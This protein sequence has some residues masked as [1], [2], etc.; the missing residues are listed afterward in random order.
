MEIKTYDFVVI[1][2]GLSG[3]AAAVSSARNGMKVALIGNRPVPGGNAS[4]EIGIDVNGACY[5]SLYSPSV[6]ARETGLIEELKQEIFHRAGYEPSLNKSAQY[7]ATML[8]FLYDEENLDLYLNTQATDVSVK[9]N[10][11]EYVDCIQ[12]TSERK[13]RFFASTFADC[14]G[15][16]FVGA[17]AGAKFMSG[18]EGRAEYGENLAPEQPSQITN[19]CSLLFS[20]VRT[21]KEEKFIPPHFAYDITKLDFFKD[22]G[23]K[24]RSF[25]QSKAEDGGF[26]G[27]WWVEYGGHIDCIKD[28]EKITKE[29][30]KLVYGIWDYIKNSG[31]FED[32]WDAK[33][34]SVGSVLGKRESRRFVGEY[35][36]N[37]KD[38]LDKKDFEDA[39]YVAGWPMDIHADYGIYDDGPATHWNYVP[40]MYNAPLST[41]YSVNIE[42][43]VFAGRNTSCTRVA[44]S[45]V[46]VMS[47]CAVGGQAIGT[48]VALCKKYG[49]SL[50]ELRAER[51]GE[52]QRL[53]LR[54]D[55]TIMGYKEECRLKNLKITS[56]KPKTLEN[57][58]K[59]HTK[60]LEKAVM[61]SLPVKTEGLDSVEIGIKN[62]SNA[63]QVLEYA[64]LLGKYKEC[65]MPEK[66]LFE[67]NISIEKGFDGYLTLPLNVKKIQGDKIFIILR[68]NEN[69]ETY[70]TEE[71]LTGAPSF[72]VWN[73]QPNLHDSR[74]FGQKRLREDVCFRNVTPC[75]DVFDAENVTGGY[76]RPYGLPN[77]FIS[78]GKKDVFLTL[79]FDETDLEE[80]Q[81][82]F[83]TD[84]AEDI[85]MQQAKT[86]VK[87]Y[88]VVFE[89]KGQKQEIR[90]TDNYKRINSFKPAFP[91]Q[92]IT[93]L[94]LENYGA[95][96]FELFGIKAYER[97]K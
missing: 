40:G 2:C 32:V 71:S 49:C 77:L 96:N 85:I 62:T 73:T 54:N 60:L 1:G 78:K 6:Y 89:G 35:V 50:K 26:Q 82:V 47:T 30:Q 57:P 56:S 65:Y 38:I 29:L 61:L 31:K 91:V 27:F 33:L 20:T 76:N 97:Q 15:D 37:Q 23:T 46:R 52:L 5:N 75:Q 42:N 88:I 92:K 84:L 13:I 10:R 66:L 53:L 59:T 87:D 93:F 18:S 34:L 45:S 24:N 67:G 14:T 19:G 44:N 39:C 12:L 83:N 9:E 95:E 7:N 81:F 79:E 22:L 8:D 90:V 74:I 63:G 64:V 80:V 68:E 4:V 11:I 28:S 41:L 16:G 69:L 21:G 51:V 48:A 17:K 3:M 58:N 36:L 25:Y 70:M 55:Q 43:L 86:T 72:L 94:P